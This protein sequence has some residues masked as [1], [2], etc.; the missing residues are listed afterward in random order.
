MNVWQTS[1]TQQ[2]TRQVEIIEMSSQNKICMAVTDEWTQR[3]S[4]LFCVY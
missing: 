3:K 4:K 1:V 2:H